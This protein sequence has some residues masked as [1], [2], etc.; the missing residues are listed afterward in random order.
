[1][2]RSRYERAWCTTSTARGAVDVH[3]IL[4]C[5]QL[6]D[7]GLGIRLWEISVGWRVFGYGECCSGT[8]EFREDG[9]SAGRLMCIAVLARWYAHTG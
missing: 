7:L 6:N 2:R 1:M 9:I 3:E 4:V 5:T 8:V